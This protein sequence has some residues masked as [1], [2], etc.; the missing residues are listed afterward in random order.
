MACEIMRTDGAVIC[1]RISGV[2]KLTDLQTL[3]LAG[4]DV[5]RQG[6]KPRL[7][8]MLENFQGWEK[9]ADWGDVGFQ[10]AHGND[11]DKIALVGDEKWKD[12]VFAFVGKGL[13]TT[14]IE[15]FTHSALKEA[16]IWIGS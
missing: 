7:L 10:I 13:R 15:F 8:V 6:S 12:N 1:A 9:G 4:M 3:Q 11:I 5:I 2:M 14:K 16:D